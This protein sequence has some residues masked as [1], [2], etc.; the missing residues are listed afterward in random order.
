MTKNRIKQEIIRELSISYFIS[1]KFSNIMKVYDIEKKIKESSSFKNCFCLSTEIHTKKECDFSKLRE[2]KTVMK[3]YFLPEYLSLG[4][5]CISEIR[6]LSVKIGNLTY[7]ISILLTLSEVGVG[8]ITFILEN[9]RNLCFQD[10]IELEFMTRDN[11]TF[12]FN[13]KFEKIVQ[14]REKC[15][16]KL[17]LMEISG[18]LLSVLERD[19]QLGIEGLNIDKSVS[20]ENKNTYLAIFISDPDERFHLPTDFLD[21]YKKEVF[22]IL[23]ISYQFKDKNFVNSRKDKYIEEVIMPQK[24]SRK[25]VIY[26]QCRDRMVAISTMKYFKDLY[27]YTFPWYMSYIAMLIVLRIQSELLLK[28]NKML[29]SWET[30][31]PEKLAKFKIS[32]VSGL[33]EY[34]LLGFYM[35][36]RCKKFLDN[37]KKTMEMDVLMESIKYR[38]SILSE[39]VSDAYS[40]RIQRENKATAM[41]INVLSLIVSVSVAMQI[42]KEFFPAT[43]GWGSLMVWV[44]II[45]IF[46]SIK[47]LMLVLTD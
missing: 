17:N 7:E 30:L 32:I 43:L 42:V 27:S 12:V 40:Y 14:N 3:N 2:I 34:F 6:G 4:R 38:L 19:L 39:A 25:H 35:G 11:W 45:T 36:P 28:L 8:V 20:I 44:I 31:S 15:R 10:L 18:I 21:H 22:R 16:N 1:F 33:E 23:A 41:A 13:E 47:K 5:F 29:Y 46:F 9:L 26:L 37:T 24:S